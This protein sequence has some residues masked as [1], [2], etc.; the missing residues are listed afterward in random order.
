MVANPRRHSDESITLEHRIHNLME[1]VTNNGFPFDIEG[2]RELE[3]DL[4]EVVEEK[5]AAAIEHFGSWWVP[6]KWKTVGKEY[7]T[8]VM[9]ADGK[10]CSTT[11]ARSRRSRRRS[12][13]ARNSARTTRAR[14]G[15][16]SSSPRS[17]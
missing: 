4:R 17:R 8:E 10:P 13:R 5:E 2:G 3:T 16:R 11:T 7:K 9:D 12:G 6:S 15:A 14:I 1:E